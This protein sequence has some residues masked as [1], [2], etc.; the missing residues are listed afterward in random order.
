L[1]RMGSM[2][3]TLHEFRLWVGIRVVFSLDKMVGEN[4]T[5]NIN[6]LAC[7]SLSDASRGDVQG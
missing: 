5:K 3:N 2:R 6:E 4:A 1:A 7:F